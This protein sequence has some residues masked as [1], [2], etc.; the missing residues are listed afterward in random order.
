M[1][2]IN[3]RNGFLGFEVSIFN[4]H[5]HADVMRGN[6][7][8]KQM[9]ID[10]R[11]IKRAFLTEAE[12]KGWPTWVRIVEYRKRILAIY[13][14]KNYYAGKTKIK[15]NKTWLGVFGDASYDP[16]VLFREYYPT[17]RSHKSA[18]IG[19][20]GLVH[21]NKGNIKAQKERAR[22][23][24]KTSRQLKKKFEEYHKAQ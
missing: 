21:I 3:S 19:E 1:S 13:Q 22:A 4:Q 23:R 16:W 9:V 15:F 17:G 5:I 2:I 14:E 8:I 24:A 7:N 10:R 12:S 11:A 20:D 18:K 6:P